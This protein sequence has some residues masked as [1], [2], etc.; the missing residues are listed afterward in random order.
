[1][2]E[3]RIHVTIPEY[4]YD[5]DN[6]DRF[7]DAFMRTHPEIGPSVSQ[8]IVTGTLSVTFSLDAEDANEAFHLARRAFEDGAS[9]TGL[10][11]TKMVAVEVSLVPAEEFE[12]VE[13][14]DAVPT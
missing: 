10:E 11:P 8:N 1:L 9:A 4:G 6:G 12:D 7:V 13:Q 5:L 2:P 14:R 3:H